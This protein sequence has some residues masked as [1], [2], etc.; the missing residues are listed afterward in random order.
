MKRRFFLSTIIVLLSCSCS[1]LKENVDDINYVGIGVLPMQLEE[2]FPMTKAALDFTNGINFIWESEDT[3]GIFP[4]RGSQAYFDMHSSAGTSHAEFEGGGWALK[5]SGEYHY[6][7][8][9]PFN[10]EHKH[11]DK[12]PCGYMGQKQNGNGQ[13]NHLKPYIHMA[14]SAQA[15]S[16]GALNFGLKRMETLMRFN[17]KM[18]VA[19]QFT[20]LR[21]ARKDGEELVVSSNVNIS[22]SQPVVSAYKRQPFYDL[23]LENIGLNSANGTITLYLMLPPQNLSGTRL[24]ISVDTADGDCCRAETPGK[25]MLENNAYGYEAV[26]VSDFASLMEPFEGE[27]GSWT[28]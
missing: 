18:P 26:L 5:G 28:E 10:H 21:I 15:P 1:Q 3:V 11:L 12:I 22:G 20:K 2:G 23:S 7:A 9:F 17:L 25:D 24:L 27:E 14:S 6:S 8:Y 4:N 13:F 16:N 19:G